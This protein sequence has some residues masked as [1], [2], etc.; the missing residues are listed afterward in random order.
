M[1]KLILAY[2][3]EAGRALEKGAAINTLVALPVRERIGRFKYTAEEELQ[4]N[5]DAILAELKTQ[6]EDAARAEETT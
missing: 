5:Y 1:M 4:Q 3:D 6:A 2:Y